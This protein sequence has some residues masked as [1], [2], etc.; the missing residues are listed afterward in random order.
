[1]GAIAMQ[2]VCGDLNVEAPLLKAK[3][4]ALPLVY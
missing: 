4:L 2:A 3:L 1:M